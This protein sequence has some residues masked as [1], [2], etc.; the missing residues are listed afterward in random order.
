[1]DDLALQAWVERISLESFGIPFR[2]RA[3][4]NPRL[5]STGGRYFLKTHNI[6]I[7]PSQLAAY[8]PEETE[9]II[10]HELCHY[11]LHL[12]KRGYRHRDADFRSL[13]AQVGGSR[14]CKSLPDRA[15]RPPKPPKYVLR[16]RSCG[17]EYKRKKRMD[18]RRYACG[19]CGGNLQLN[20]LDFKSEP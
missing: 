8:G 7:N 9:K 17:H 19:Q 4:F 18:P 1:M 12:G 14:F 10:K 13:L 15:Q 6:E 16:C 2:H 11:H 3:T 5:R 20:V